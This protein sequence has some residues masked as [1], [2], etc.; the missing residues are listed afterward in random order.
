MFVDF[1]EAIRILKKLEQQYVQEADYFS[2]GDSQSA[3]VN[4]N[5]MGERIVAIKQAIRKLEEAWEEEQKQFAKSYG[6][7]VDLTE[8]DFNA[9]DVTDL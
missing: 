6:Q 5:R 3:M 2:T 1:N 4:C 8:N 9:V 7:S